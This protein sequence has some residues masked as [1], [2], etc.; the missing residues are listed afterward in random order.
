MH[1]FTIGYNAIVTNQTAISTYHE[2]ILEAIYSLRQGLSFYEEAKKVPPEVASDQSMIVADIF[3]RY[4]F[5]MIANSLE[6]AGNALLLSLNL[7]KSYYDE[8]ERTSTLI[9]FKL[10]CDFNGKRLDQGDVKFARVKD[11][12][13]C[14][15]EFVHPKP[16]RATYTIASN[17]SEIIFEIKKTKNRQYPHYFNEIK[18]MHV[19]TA[20]DDTLTFISWVCFD[21]C[22]LK[23]QD[24][25]LRLGLGSY[26]STGDIDIIGIDNNINFDKRTFGHG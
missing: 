18:P 6:A 17:S 20:L 19:L 26:G 12:V 8:L 22:K 24:G 21:I 10:F 1:I 4:S 11:I 14:R 15:N 2:Y 7:D 23:V 13:D 3:S 5:L 9:K 16:K 25:A